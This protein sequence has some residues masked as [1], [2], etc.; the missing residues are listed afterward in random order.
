ML[1]RAAF[2]VATVVVATS[3]TANAA[4]IT[5]TFNTPF[6]GLVYTEAGLNISAEPGSA[7]VNVLNGVLGFGCCS[8]PI[9]IDWSLTLSG[10]GLFD[11]ISIDAVHVD[12]PDPVTFT[13]WLGGVA[14][15]LHTFSGN[16]AGF[17][18][19]GFTGLD[20]V[21]ITANMATFA[22]PQF[23]NLTYDASAVPAPAA[24][25]LL[26]VGLGG[27]AVARRRRA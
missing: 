26:V 9:V 8:P 7:N 23:D 2:L 5:L 17:N 20:E 10:G 22:D 4:P 14:V 12:S 13:G 25:P 16:T 21:T 24:L 3:V 18:F 15:A 27:L 11:L 1:L 19:T 6:N